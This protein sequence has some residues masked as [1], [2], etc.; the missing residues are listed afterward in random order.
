MTVR[1]AAVAAILALAGCAAA[2][3]SSPSVPPAALG[4]VAGSGPALPSSAPSA[5]PAVSPRAQTVG[6]NPRACAGVPAT[7]VSAAL[8]LP[9][10]RVVGAVEGPVTVCAYTGRYEVIVRF[11]RHENAAEFA[12]AKHATG[13]DHQLITA[14]AGLGHGAYLATYTLAKP[15]VNTLVARRGQLAIFISSPA[16]LRAERN[17]MLHLLA[18]V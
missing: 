4:G 9:L 7:M 6:A 15:A 16:P 5:G 10:G 11:Q 18:R 8:K 14:V 3:C 12:D 13:A 17:L 2:A 1:T